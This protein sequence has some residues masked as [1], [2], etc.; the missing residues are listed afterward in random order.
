MIYPQT[1]QPITNTIVNAEVV[2][3]APDLLTCNNP[4]ESIYSN[5]YFFGV[6]NVFYNIEMLLHNV[7]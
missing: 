4:D 3:L 1:P 7:R 2:G 5:K 6:D